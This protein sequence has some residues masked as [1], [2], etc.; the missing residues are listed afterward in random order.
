MARCIL[1][2]S[3]TIGVN[4]FARSEV[5]KPEPKLF[6]GG[7]VGEGDCL[8]KASPLERELCVP[9]REWI[10]FMQMGNNI[11]VMLPR[12]PCKGVYGKVVEKLVEVVI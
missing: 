9:L 4:D 1:E 6:V 2:F 8:R 3:C 12:R 10:K 7:G 11:A 5:G